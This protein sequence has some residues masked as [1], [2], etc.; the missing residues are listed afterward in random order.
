M[1]GQLVFLL[2]LFW[3]CDEVVAVRKEGE[4]LSENDL[5]FTLTAWQVINAPFM[6]LNDLS[7]IVADESAT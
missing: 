1:Y 7:K 3:S 4:V 5:D 2:I 6:L